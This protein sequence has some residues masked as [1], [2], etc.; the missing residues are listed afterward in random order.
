M[1]DGVP[2]I[3]PPRGASSSELARSR[4][5][6][7]RAFAPAQ[8]CETIRGLVDP[9]KERAIAS[10]FF[11]KSR[12]L[13]FGLVASGSSSVGAAGVTAH[14]WPGGGSDDDRR[15]AADDGFKHR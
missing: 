14:G 13:A 12:L 1:R 11:L 15:P 2:G 9:R 3:P 8:R 6:P 7:R 4:M 5:K 10:V